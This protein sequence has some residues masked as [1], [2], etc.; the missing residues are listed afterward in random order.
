MQTVHTSREF[1]SELRDLRTRVLSMGARSEQITRTA[2]EA[3]SQ[4]RTALAVDV[5]QLEAELDQDEVDVQALVLR[6]LALRQPV[7]GD[8]RFLA[9][10][11]RL[12]TDLERVGDEATNIT[13]CIVE[14]HDAARSITTNELKQMDQDVQEMLH[15]SLRAFVERD[16]DTAR[17]VLQR[18][19]AVD[20]LCAK[21]ISKMEGYVASHGDDVDAGMRIMSVARYLERIADHATNIAEEVIFMVRGEDVRHGVAASQTRGGDGSAPSPR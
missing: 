1:E 12:I 11:L 8:L 2:F 6:V 5:P 17:A 15:E 9:A 14:G 10:A 13:E 16:P 19:D 3:F 21:V 18:D 4:G 7:A 20:R